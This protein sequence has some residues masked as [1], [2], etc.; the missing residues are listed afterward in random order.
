ML[1]IVGNGGM[2]ARLEMIDIRKAVPDTVN[3]G[4]ANERM[5][6]GERISKMSQKERDNRR[7]V[8]ST[9]VQL[10]GGQVAMRE[11]EVTNASAGMRGQV[12]CSN[13]II[14]WTTI[15]SQEKVSPVVPPVIL[16]RS[17]MTH[18]TRRVREHE[19]RALE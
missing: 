7:V 13:S 10:E 1:N 2:N 16:T 14:A 3:I 6:P 18:P 8:P 5:T 15:G 12:T 4:G 17:Q 11:V 9:E 19:A